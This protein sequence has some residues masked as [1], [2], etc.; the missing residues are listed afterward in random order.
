MKAKFFSALLLGG[1]IQSAYAAHPLVSDDSSTQ[2]NGNHQIEFNADQ[3]T[4]SGANTHVGASTYT[5]GAL[6]NLDV[7]VNVPVT[8]ASMAGVNDAS[9]G[10]KWRFADGETA[11]VALKSELLLP[12]GDTSKGL[13]NGRANFGLTLIGTYLAAPWSLHGNVGFAVNRFQKQC[14][15]DANRSMLW[16]ASVAASYNVNERWQLVGD[17][18]LTRNPDVTSNTALGYFLVGTI[19]SPNEKLDLDVGAKVGVGCKACASQIDHQIGI[20][21]T[22]RF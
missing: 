17:A 3:L 15:Q 8:H 22:W 6:G 4:Q 9:L 5:F 11:S 13:G 10:A 14:D 18:G 19:Y 1:L 7:F 2:G 16:R 20:G 21:V 12:T